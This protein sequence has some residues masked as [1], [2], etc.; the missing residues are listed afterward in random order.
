MVS[1]HDTKF[2][3]MTSV[4]ST[5][6][7]Y[8]SVFPNSSKFGANLARLSSGNSVSHHGLLLPLP[9]AALKEDT[10][11]RSSQQCTAK[12]QSAFEVS[13]SLSCQNAVCPKSFLDLE[14]SIF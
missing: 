11:S 1:C 5:S 2:N 9:A 10:F 4:V 12:Q 6:H 3:Y 14:N 7:V 8:D 13:V